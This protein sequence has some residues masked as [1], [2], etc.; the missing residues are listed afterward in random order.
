MKDFVC[1]PR[2]LAPPVMRL[3]EYLAIHPL[4]TYI[5]NCYK[6]LSGTDRTFVA[7]GNHHLEYGFPSTHSTNSVSIALFF[8]GYLHA[9]SLSPFSS[10]AS[11]ENSSPFGISP[12]ITYIF[13][14][15]LLLLYTISIVF[16]RIYTAMHSFTD[17]LVGVVLGAII[18]IGVTDAE[19]GGGLGLAWGR[20][21][22]EWATGAHTVPSLTPPLV[23]TTV[24]LTLVNQHPQPVDDCPCF[25]DALAM[26]AVVYGALL[27]RWACVYF[28]M[29]GLVERVGGPRPM[30]GSGWVLSKEELFVN[31]TSAFGTMSS[32]NA[33]EVSPHTTAWIASL[34]ASP[35]WATLLFTLTALAKLVLGI[36]II[37]AWRL[38]AKSVLGLVLPSV[39]RAVARIVAG[40]RYVFV[41]SLVVRM[42][43]PGLSLATGR[44]ISRVFGF[45]SSSLNPLCAIIRDVRVRC[46]VRS[47][48][49]N[50]VFLT[51]SGS[52]GFLV[53]HSQTLVRFMST[54]FCLSFRTSLIA[55]ANPLVP[56]FSSPVTTLVAFFPT[57][58]PFTR[59][60]PCILLPPSPTRH[61]LILVPFSLYLLS[62][63]CA[64]HNTQI[65]SWPRIRMALHAKSTILPPSYGISRWCTE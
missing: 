59:P 19:N 28:G 60:P 10:S 27:G 56:S 32:V 29:D 44:V 4:S 57:P 37:F 58:H 62:S 46:C 24:F 63:L 30:I 21:L 3:S 11:D 49:R 51:P 42:I 48:L 64:P 40:I 13:F 16:G 18:W 8:W 7:L 47:R 61:S 17:C 20:R 2:P 55:N 9:S 1:S 65:P 34:S 54:F 12:T 31:A 5:S 35:L 6:E 15:F 52:T 41:L 25:E 45:Y 53:P 39:F 23:L 50:L 36:S 14:C 22:E 33:T 26:G 38:F 43:P